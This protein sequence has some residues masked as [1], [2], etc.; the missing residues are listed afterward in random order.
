MRSLRWRVPLPRGPATRR[1]GRGCPGPPPRV[2][3][4]SDQPEGE[5]SIAGA[6][7]DQVSEVAPGPGEEVRRCDHLAGPS[8][9]A[10]ADQFEADP[11]GI[12]VVPDE[13]HDAEP[14]DR[15]VGPADGHEPVGPG[16]RRDGRGGLL[17]TEG[18]VDELCPHRA[19]LR[20]IDL[21]DDPDQRRVQPDREGHGRD[22]DERSLPGSSP[23][24][25]GGRA[26]AAMPRRTGAPNGSRRPSRRSRPPSG[27]S[28]GRSHASD[29][30]DRAR[31]DRPG[32]MV[33]APQVWRSPAFRRG[34]RPR[35]VG[36]KVTAPGRPNERAVVSTVGT[37]G[38][39]PD[40]DA[41]RRPDRHG[42]KDLADQDRADLTR[43]VADRLHDPDVAVARQDD[44]ADD[45]G[46]RECRG[47]R[48]R[49]SRTRAG[50]GRTGPR[51]RSTLGLR[52]EVGSAG[53]DGVRAGD[54]R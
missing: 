44:P 21:A 19:R 41:G 23:P 12:P 31:P 5:R 46:D 20:A 27:G 35:P 39:H 11:A 7:G 2:E 13:G 36:E 50:P 18:R 53:D 15:G 4:L 9:P 52:V 48:G 3:D 47:E 26:P 24:G 51:A 49:R 33:R 10:T 17:R 54:R 25:P 37:A 32:W 1:A 38:E 22:P 30:A 43:R 45:V 8:E 16:V 14:G 40:H 28:T 34:P 42:D 29:R 6:H